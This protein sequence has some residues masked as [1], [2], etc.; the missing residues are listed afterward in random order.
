MK[1]RIASKTLVLCIYP[2]IIFLFFLSARLNNQA[3]NYSDFFL[4][5]FTGGMIVIWFYLAKKENNRALNIGLLFF[6]VSIVIDAL[7]EI[8][9]FYISDLVDLIFEEAFGVIGLGLITIGLVVNSNENNL[10]LKKI[11][12]LSTVDSL[13]KLPN[14][15]KIRSII[16]LEIEDAKFSDDTIAIFLVDFDNFKHINDLY[17]YEFG[18]EVLIYLSKKLKSIAESK[19]FIGRLGDDEF[20]IVANI[21]NDEN[22]IHTVSRKII[23]TFNNVQKIDNKNIHISASIGVSCFPKDGGKRSTLIRN[24]DAALCNVK[25]N[26][27]NCYELYT[28]NIIN[29]S[30]SDM[31][32]KIGIINALKYNSFEVHYQPIISIDN[33]SDINYEALIRWNKNGE[34]I[35]PNIFIP[36]AEKYGLINQIDFYVLSRVCCDIN[37]YDFL[38]NENARVSINLSAKTIIS[39]HS[40][41]KIQETIA[42]H[43]TS[44]SKLAFEITETAILLDEEEAFKKINELRSL[45]F[46]VSLDDFG[47]GYSSL[48]HIKKLQIDSIKIDKSFIDGIG[49]NFR[50][51]ELIKGILWLT[52]S[53]N[54][55][56]IAE[57][58]ESEM[59]VNFL[60]QNGCN[61]IQGYFY[62]KPMHIQMIV[63]K[64][65]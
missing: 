54:I 33:P 24:A 36:I 31:K 29:Y 3:I 32:L 51:E 19:Y 38:N 11:K 45:G 42:G 26:G 49:V 27:K 41:L 52:K 56:S 60:K 46:E 8:E 63:K 61:K 15:K 23:E 20:I 14:R 57:G 18:D 28:D 59:Q 10:L 22:E 12:A 43:D 39:P 44:S 50:D 34:P 13:T 37:K 65:V 21:K 9:G 64:A 55:T 4:E 25:K 40:T 5:S 58:V 53:L 16:D 47:T 48:N 1:K 30:E 17:G 7:D 62:S 35:G 6:L 2:I